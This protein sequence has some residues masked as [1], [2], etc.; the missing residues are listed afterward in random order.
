MIRHVRFLMLL[1]GMVALLVACSP[2]VGSKK[3]CAAMK[4][5]P[6]GEWTVDETTNFAKHCLFK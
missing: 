1:L 3:W 2:K 5:K 6:K 4:E